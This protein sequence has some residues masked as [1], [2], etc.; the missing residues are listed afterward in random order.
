[1]TF[2]LFIDCFRLVNFFH[3]ELIHVFFYCSFGNLSRVLFIDFFR[4]VSFFAQRTVNLLDFFFPI[5]EIF[6]AP[7]HYL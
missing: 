1:M 2:F 7:V 3:S 6:T 5:S 4:L